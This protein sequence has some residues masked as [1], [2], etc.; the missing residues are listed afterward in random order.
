MGTKLTSNPIYRFLFLLVS[1][2]NGWK[3]FKNLGLKT[4]VVAQK[5]F[6]PLIAL[7]SLSVFMEKIYNDASLESLL[8]SAIITFVAF[9]F[10]YFL[11]LILTAI[12][13]KS[14]SKTKFQ[15]DFGKTYVMI[16]LSSLAVFYILNNLFPPLEPI[17]VFTPIYTIY[18]IIKGSRFLRI[19]EEETT[20]TNIVLSI[21][22]IG[23][24]IALSYF[25]S[26]LLTK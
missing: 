9:F 15:A 11:I 4:D 25:F 5:L 22:I 3:K 12:L 8:Q 6:Y 18:L 2:L 17:L 14:E 23:V 1:P 13:L 21:L 26:L 20:H 10:G 24:P 7:T 19:P 16:N